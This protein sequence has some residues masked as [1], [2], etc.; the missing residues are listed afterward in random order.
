MSSFDI[1]KNV[2]FDGEKQKVKW[3]QTTTTDLP[4]GMQYVG[5]MNRI[6]FD[7]LIDFLWDCYEDN[8]ISFKEFKK[9]FEDFRNF[10][11]SKKDLFKK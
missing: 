2:Y 11:D 5:K 8:D 1:Y 9:H 4:I 10:I 3:T 6:E 7:L